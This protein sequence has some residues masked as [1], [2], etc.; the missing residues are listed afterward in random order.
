M[1]RMVLL[2]C[3]AAATG[4]CEIRLPARPGDAGGPDAAAMDASQYVDGRVDGALDAGL[5]AALPDARKAIAVV[6]PGKGNGR[7][8]PKRTPD[9]GAA[10]PQK[11]TLTIIAFP[12]KSDYRL[13]GGPW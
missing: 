5:D 11:R 7:K 13:S 1:K 8:P 12:P 2:I 6:N 10:A 9:A 3:V 4:A